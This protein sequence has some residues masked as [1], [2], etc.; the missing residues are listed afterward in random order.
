MSEQDTMSGLVI[1]ISKNNPLEVCCTDERDKQ[2]TRK[3]CMLVHGRQPGQDDDNIGSL[4]RH[5]RKFNPTGDPYH[6][7]ILPRVYN[8][9][10]DLVDN[11]GA[12][13]EGVA[14]FPQGR[15][16]ALLLKVSNVEKL[17]LHN[18]E[19]LREFAEQKRCLLHITVYD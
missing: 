5:L 9:I 10:S 14:A 4:L 19:A 8:G 2:H 3:T 11:L 15:V 18:L 16:G 7:N 6:L 1:S 13:S 17:D 12:L